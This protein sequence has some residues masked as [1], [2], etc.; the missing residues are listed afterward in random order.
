VGPLKIVGTLGWNREWQKKEASFKKECK[1]NQTQTESK[2]NK[3]SSDQLLGALLAA[4]G[5]TNH[6]CK[7]AKPQGNP[8]IIP[9]TLKQNP[10][11]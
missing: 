2:T 7:A 8:Y 9:R 4:G 1:L 10:V 6:G 5:I 11:G 3:Q